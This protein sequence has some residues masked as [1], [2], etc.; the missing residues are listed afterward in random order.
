MKVLYAI[1]GT[2]NG[3]V[4]RAREVVPFLKKMADVDI[5]LSGNHSNL[6]L[7]FE[8]KYQSKGLS[9]EYNNHGGLSYF[10]SI[11]SLEPRRISREIN[12][13][14]V[15]D[16]D[17]VISDFECISSYAARKRGIPTMAFS[18][19]VALLSEFTPKPSGINLI[20]ELILEFYAP[21]KYAVGLHFK[22]YD[23]YIFTP[24]IRQEVRQLQPINLGHNTVYLPAFGDLEIINILNKLPDTRWEVFSRETKTIKI[25]RNITIRPIQNEAFLKSLE[26]CNGILTSAGFE[27][28][29]EAL[30]LGKKVFVIP[31]SGQYE[32]LCNATALSELGIPM[33]RKLDNS[34]IASLQAWTQNSQN[35][36]V[37]FPNITE[38]LIEQM[39]FEQSMFFLPTLAV[40]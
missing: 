26:T 21:A 18:H 31:I 38:T 2:G 15:E 12:D 3:H 39:L 11:R 6:Q 25:E 27:T 35:I 16:Y 13:L 30:F 24:I 10:N 9:F 5:F 32:Q 40:G 8:I 1:Q 20:G 7:P 37:H 23:D 33:A 28:P 36:Q 17:L 22:E 4:S 34:L 14:P 29:S 19:Q